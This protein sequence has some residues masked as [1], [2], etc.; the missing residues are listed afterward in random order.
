VGRGAL[1]TAHEISDNL[2]ALARQSGDDVLLLQA[3]HASWATAFLRGDFEATLDHAS[4]GIKLY[5]TVRDVA[6]VETYGSH[7]AAV[8]ARAF[9]ARALALVGRTREAA[10][11]SH[12]AIAL[13][14]DLGHP[15]SLA[16]AY[17]FAAAVDQTRHDADSSLE[18]AAAAVGLAREQDFRLLLAWASA[19][20]GW[21]SVEH[22]RGEQGLAQIRSAIA[23]AHATGC[24]QFLAHL[25]GLLAEAYLR[26]RRVDAGM[27]AIDEALALMQRTG[28]RFWEA[29]L[30]RLHG[31][32][33]LAA[34]AAE[35]VREAE[36]AFAQAIA[37]GRSQGARLLVLRAAISA[38]RLWVRLGRGEEARQ[39][40]RCAIRELDEPLASSDAMAT[41]AL[42]GDPW[43]TGPVAPPGP[44]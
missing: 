5:E 38:G 26:D 42:L 23:G 8:C 4:A 1:A 18:H 27:A 41:N 35:S 28:E 36:R 32:L 24:E 10:R 19:F 11:T 43:R 39:L 2:L 44:M 7:D 21:A 16:L 25:H 3:H 40:V 29:E 6:A 13:A 9:G 12:E 15:F 33:L 34:G 30:Q 20:A 31:E 17:V 14:R 37:V 22:G